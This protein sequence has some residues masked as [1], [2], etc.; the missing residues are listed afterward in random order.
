MK[1]AACIL[2]FMIGLATDLHAQNELIFYA[3]HIDFSMDGGYFHINGM[4]TFINATHHSITSG[5]IYPLP[6]PDHNIVSANVVDIKN[7]SAYKYDWA[8]NGLQFDLVVKAG[9]T[10][11]LCISY[12][13]RIKSI[14]TYI[15][16]S[17]KYW[18]KPLQIAEYSLTVNKET[19]IKS[20]SYQPDTVDEKTD[21]DIYYWHKKRFMPRKDLIVEIIDN[22]IDKSGDK[23]KEIAR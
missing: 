13:Q 19:R 17:T 12:N 7:N 10:V 1:S 18:Q 8:P 11:E 6:D 2:V 15:L 3:E 23:S 20:F 14:N 4:Y 9:D 5:I 21:R 22:T 16:T